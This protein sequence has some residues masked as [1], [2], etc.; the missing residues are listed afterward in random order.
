M[1]FRAPIA[2]KLANLRAEIVEI[3]AR[4]SFTPAQRKA[5]YE[6]QD[7]HCIACEEALSGGF[8]IDHVISLGIGG[9][10][11]PS[12]WVG[13][14]IP[15]HKAKTRLDRAAQASAKRIISRETNGAKPSKFKSRPLPKGSRPM[16]SRGWK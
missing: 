16:Q 10:H 12:N 8:H 6:A 15:C 14:C 7:G 5:V 13:I 4:K 1:T 9:K 3:Q 2:E 11:E